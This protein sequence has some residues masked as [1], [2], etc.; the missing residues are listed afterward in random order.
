MSAPE[1]QIEEKKIEEN[2]K[3]EIKTENNPYS[4]NLFQEIMS[5]KDQNTY[6]ISKTLEKKIPEIFSYL[7][8]DS[9]INSITNKSQLLGYLEVLFKNIDYNSEI[10]FCK[11]SNGKENLNVFEVLIHEFV[12]NTK[13]NLNNPNEEQLKN[14]ENYKEQLKNIFSILL[15]KLS[16]D[17]K[18]YHYI[19]SFLINYLNQ[20]NNKIDTS[21]KL[22]SEQISL[23][24][25]LLHIY[26]QCVQH[27]D[28]P[29]NYLYFNNTI[30]EENKSEY[31]IT[32][33]NKENI[34]RKK[35]L[36]LDDS[37]N[38]VFFIK[39]ISK[40][41]I[42]N[43]DP[44]HNSGLFELVFA[45][46]TKNISFNIDN[47]NNL[48]NNITKDKITKLEENKFINILIKFNLKDSLKIEIYLNNKKIDFPNDQIAIK[49]NEKSKIK[50]K[51]EIK[52]MN[53]FKNFIG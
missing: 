52:S 45:D 19:F 12:L 30:K 22:N 34:N 2:E 37:L 14:I 5:L 28:D 15:S 47:E 38:I 44:N 21:Q 6:I 49:D 41:Y 36:S 46:P 20:K 25:E 29:Q 51:Y 9:S 23:I 27:I 4:P 39:L 31:L 18:A 1:N 8:E 26:Y 42:K 32:V 16:F 43:V 13:T 10:F 17:K 33:Q 3:P 48:I 11:K 7:L 53:F 50:E 40:E 35:I 24:L